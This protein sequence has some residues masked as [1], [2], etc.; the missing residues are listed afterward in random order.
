MHTEVLIGLIYSI[1]ELYIDDILFCGSSETDYLS[2]L[3]TILIWLSDKGITLN[4]N[5]CK[6][7]HVLDRSGLSLSEKN[8]ESI[9]NFKLPENQKELRSFLGLANYFRD[10]IR[11]HSIIVHPL[12]DTVKNYKPKPRRTWLKETKEAFNDIKEAINACPKLYYLDDISPVY[13]QTDA[14]DYG[15]G[16]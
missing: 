10:H 7:G 9:V 12:R 13:L 16:A 5:K 8:K 15:V 1:C 11:N 14:S 4:P 3:E 6:L 2:H